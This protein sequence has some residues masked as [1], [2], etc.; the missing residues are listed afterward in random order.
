[1]ADLQRLG[2]VTDWDE[3]REVLAT[4]EKE[5]PALGSGGDH[6]VLIYNG[7]EDL[8][9]YVTGRALKP[10]DAAGTCMAAAQLLL[11]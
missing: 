11:E 2:V 9:T 7:P 5:M 10:S 1:M 6:I 8:M 4:W 3:A